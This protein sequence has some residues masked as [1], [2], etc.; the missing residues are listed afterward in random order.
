[1]VRP[2]GSI[3]PCSLAPRFLSLKIGV[4]GANVAPHVVMVILRYLG[5]SSGNQSPKICSA[6]Y[7]APRNR[8]RSASWI[9]S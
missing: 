9:S 4:H 2:N 6:V 1:M 3:M 7:E 5:G 8:G